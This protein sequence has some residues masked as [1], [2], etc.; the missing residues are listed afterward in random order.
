[1][2]IDPSTTKN[3]KIFKLTAP[4]DNVYQGKYHKALFVCSAGILRS[5]SAAE[6]FAQKHGWNTR[7]AGSEGYALI[8][9]S[10]NLLK[11]ADCVYFM[12]DENYQTVANTFF[13]LDE[14]VDEKLNCSLVLQIPDHYNFREPELLYKLEEQINVE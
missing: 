12:Q 5:A 13:G 4:W 6:Y 2:I 14:D 7:A 11:W 10:M 3:D 8:P 9:V 1:M